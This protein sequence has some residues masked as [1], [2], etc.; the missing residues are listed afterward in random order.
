[1]KCLDCRLSRLA[2]GLDFL[3]FPND[4]G[5]NGS[6]Y[7]TFIV[8][9]CFLFCNNCFWSI[10]DMKR[11]ISDVQHNASDKNHRLALPAVS[12]NKVNRRFLEG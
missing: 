3:D 5:P 6:N 7:E 11:D 8:Y 2:P 4:I 9:C 10:C 12:G 1:M